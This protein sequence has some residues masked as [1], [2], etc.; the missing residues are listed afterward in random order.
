MANI[1]QYVFPGAN[2]QDLC[3]VQNTTGMMNLILNGNLASSNDSTQVNFLSYGYSRQI[4]FTST[5]DLS[6]AKFT[7]IG[8]Q[9]GVQVTETLSGPVNN[10]IYSTNI[11]DVVSFVTVDRAV[12]SI[13]VGTGYNGFFPLIPID[14]TK[15]YVNYTLSLG[16]LF[17]TNQIGT[18]VYNTL[19]NIN[20]NNSTFSNIITNNVGTL[21]TVKPASNQNLYT[22]PV[23]PTTLVPLTRN[24]LVQLSGSSLTIGNAMTLTFIQL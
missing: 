8:M 1:L 21:N 5:N 17:N 18:T 10:T 14:L 3:L 16:S 20:Q 13:Q 7:I 23:S 11:Y 12:A 24:I 4:S 6:A 2:T 9:N 19:S 15:S 22:Y